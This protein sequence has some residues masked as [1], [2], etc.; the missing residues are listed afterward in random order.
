MP[1]V[2]PHRQPVVTRVCVIATEQRVHGHEADPGI[3]RGLLL[4]DAIPLEADRVVVAQPG[5]ERVAVG[6]GA[7]RVDS[8]SDAVDLD[9]DQ[10]RSA[11][12]EAVDGAVER[13]ALGVPEVRRPGA[14]HLAVGTE[15][16]GE[17]VA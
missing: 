10:G 12:G 17:L 9:D 13:F 1:P 5:Q 15:A 11:G 4:Q 7:A 2:L 3:V 6:G 14:Q 16:V 8:R